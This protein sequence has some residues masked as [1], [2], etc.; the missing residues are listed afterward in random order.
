VRA[1]I[2]Q[3]RQEAARKAAGLAN[4]PDAAKPNDVNVNEQAR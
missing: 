3:A 4:T 1:K 2:E